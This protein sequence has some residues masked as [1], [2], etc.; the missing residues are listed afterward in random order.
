M[1]PRGKGQAAASDARA[2]AAARAKERAEATAARRESGG[3]YCKYDGDFFQAKH[4]LKTTLTAI[5]Y[6]VEEKG[7]PE[8]LEPGEIYYKREFKLHTVTVGEETSKLVCPRSFNPHGKCDVCDDIAALRKAV[9]ERRKDLTEEQYLAELKSVSAAR[10]KPRELMQVYYHE[11]DK[12][13]L[14]DEAVGGGAMSGFP[15]SLTDAITNPPRGF[16]ADVAAFYLDGKLAK[17]AGIPGEGYALEVTWKATDPNRKNSWVTPSR[18]DFVPRKEAKVPDWAWDKSV[19]LSTLLARTTN[20]QL[21][22]H[23]QG[24]DEEEEREEQAPRQPAQQQPAQKEEEAPPDDDDIPFEDLSL[25]DQLLNMSTWTKAELLDFASTGELKDDSG[26]LIHKAYA[27]KSE[28]DVKRAVLDSWEEVMKENGGEDK[29]QQEAVGG[30]FTC[31]FGYVF[32]DPEHF[33]EH[34]ECTSQCSDACYEACSD[35]ATQ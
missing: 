20:E 25:N 17:E 11:E 28:D 27:R 29:Q 22:A 2:K 3:R 9:R 6:I 19:D 24:I 30:E 18:I 8:G 5:P 21:W 31:E 7:H 14:M 1:P 15:V 34:D 16:G 4:N 33:A 35:A 12:V 23:Y 13:M 32:G 26:K 10:A